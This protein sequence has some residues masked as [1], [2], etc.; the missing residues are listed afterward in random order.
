MEIVIT[1]NCW[2]YRKKKLNKKVLYIVNNSYSLPTLGV[3]VKGEPR[4]DWSQN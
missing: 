1:V 3:P 4:K 2:P